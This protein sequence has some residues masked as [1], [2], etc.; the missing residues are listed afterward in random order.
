MLSTKDLKRVQILKIEVIRP[1][2]MFK[3]SLQTNS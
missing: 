2:V 3:I 1:E